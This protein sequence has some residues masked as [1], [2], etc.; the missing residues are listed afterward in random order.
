MYQV[1]LAFWIR[2]RP[3]VRSSPRA[4]LS[5]MP[6]ARVR[7][8]GNASFRYSGL[9]SSWRSRANSS[10]QRASSCWAWARAVCARRT[11]AAWPRARS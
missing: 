6:F 1:R 3:R 2:C 9:P 10:W 8:M 7:F 11:R 4:S 5:V